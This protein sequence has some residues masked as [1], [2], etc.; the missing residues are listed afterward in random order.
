MC[1]GRA[2]TDP[3]G[4]EAGIASRGKCPR[5]ICNTLFKE[6]SIKKFLFSATFAT[7]YLKF[8]NQKVFT[9]QFTYF[10][11]VVNFNISEVFVNK[12][13]QK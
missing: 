3:S 1:I 13:G 6:I 8:F 5:Y 10:I 7:H 11:F 2:S 9:L 12:A 4:G